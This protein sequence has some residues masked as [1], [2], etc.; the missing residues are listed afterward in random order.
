MGES[1]GWDF[2]HSREGTCSQ[3]R[4]KMSHIV[5][6]GRG[7]VG[8][9]GQGNGGGWGGPYGENILETCIKML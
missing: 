2:G 1:V 3:T 5:G 9:G 6:R 8:G 7:L 4:H